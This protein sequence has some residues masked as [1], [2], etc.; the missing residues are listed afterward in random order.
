MRH[1]ISILLQ[2]ESG[3]LS[4]VAAMFSNR[5]FNIESLSVAPTEDE[6]VSRLTLVTSGAD[7]VI[8]QINK[9]LGK[10][11]DVV[12]M[13]DM[14]AGDHIERELALLKLQVGPSALSELRQ[15]SEQF[16]ARVLDD[17]PEHFTLELTGSEQQLDGFIAALPQG[18]DLLAVVRSGPLAITRGPQQLAAR[19]AG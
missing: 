19:L 6:T 14:T 8:A 2:N 4:R 3:A 15:R 11:I 9:Q 17:H 10:L 5:G 7:E 18:A 13:A 12:A 1:V 16:G